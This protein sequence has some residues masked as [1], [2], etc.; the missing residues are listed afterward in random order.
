[1]TNILGLFSF[2]VLTSSFGMEMYLGFRVDVLCIAFRSIADGL[3][4][5]CLK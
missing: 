5:D 1:L 4:S 2:C 3:T